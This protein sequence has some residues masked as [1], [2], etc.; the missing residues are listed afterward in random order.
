M[1][2]YEVVTALRSMY[3]NKIYNHT[4]LIANNQLM[5][6]TLLFRKSAN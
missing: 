4:I 6:R 1:I 2:Q 3:T 5:T